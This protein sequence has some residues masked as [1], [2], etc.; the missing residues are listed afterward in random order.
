MK[1]FTFR[2]IIS[3][4]LSI[5]TLLCFNACTTTIHFKAIAP[6][7]S[8]SKLRIVIHPISVGT[9][10][11]YPIAHSEWVDLMY[12]FAGE[13]LQDTGIYE[14]VS[15][16]DVNYAGG[17]EVRP[18]DEYWWLKDDFALMKQYAKALHADYTMLIIRTTDPAQCNI[19][20]LNIET[21]MLYSASEPLGDRGAN[22]EI[23]FPRL[24]RNLFYEAKGDLLATAVRKGRLITTEEIKKSVVPETDLALAIPSATKPVLAPPSIV[25]KK[26]TAPTGETLPHPISTASKAVTGKT[27]IVVH[28]FNASE[29]LQVVSLILSEALREELFRLGNFS[30]VNRENLAQVM[31]ENRLQQSGLVDETQVIKIGKW[32]GADEAVTGRLAQLGNSFILQVKRTDI[33]T[34]STLGFGYLKCTTG[35]EEELLVGLPELARKI[36]G[37]KQ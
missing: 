4:I 30:L 24:Y 3:A 26:K 29:Q 6:P 5:T 9:K 25:A 17:R 16:K 27:R 15:S 7:Q 31:S 28:D 22:I 14:V 13:N 36:A 21:N 12:K 8:S 34:T 20:F 37:S 23:A 18:A 11:T 33:T 2:T 19:K 10:I 32:L 35:Q 1:N